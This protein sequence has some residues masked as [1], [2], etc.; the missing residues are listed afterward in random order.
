RLLAGRARPGHAA[1]AHAD[2]VGQRRRPGRLAAGPPRR[3]ARGLP[4]P[5]GP[6][7]PRAGR[8]GPRGGLREHAL[9]RAGGRPG[10]RQPLPAPGP[11][12]RRWATPPRPA[13]TRPHPRTATPAPPSASARGSAT[14]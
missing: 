6:P 13:A 1:L 12:A 7:R 9:L 5:G 14:A 8:A 3:D 11:P 4:G 10:G 2:G